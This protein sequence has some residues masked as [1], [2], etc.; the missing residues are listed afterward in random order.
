MLLTFSCTV[1][2][3]EIRFW[4]WTLNREH[5]RCLHAFKKKIYKQQHVF[6]AGFSFKFFTFFSGRQNAQWNMSVPIH[7]AMKLNHIKGRG[8]ERIILIATHPYPSQ[9]PH[10]KNISHKIDFFFLGSE[11]PILL[12]GYIFNTNNL[13][14]LLQCR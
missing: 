14:S 9:M 7:Q 6:P 3:W 5:N 12:H 1:N 4:P 10:I 2:F 11:T 8:E 13:A